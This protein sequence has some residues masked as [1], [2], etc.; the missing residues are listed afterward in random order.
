[1]KND[2]LT[3]ILVFIMFTL[4]YFK[5]VESEQGGSPLSCWLVKLQ[6]T[7]QSQYFCYSY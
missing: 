1:M 7:Q 4:L 2:I 6:M 5:V 3:L